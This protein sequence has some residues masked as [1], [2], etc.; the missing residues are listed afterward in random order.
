M[1]V[2]NLVITGVTTN[3]AIETTAR[4]AGDR[5]YCPIVVE[6][7]VAAHLPDDHEGA[8]ATATWWVSKSTQ[9]VVDLFS[10]LLPEGAALKRMPYGA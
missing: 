9:E 8:L 7:G 2:E 3:T 4:D 6:D 1:G 5:G 10:P